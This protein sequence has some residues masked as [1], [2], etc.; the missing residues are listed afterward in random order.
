MNLDSKVLSW[1]KQFMVLTRMENEEGLKWSYRQTQWFSSWREGCDWRWVH[2]PFG[3]RVYVCTCVCVYVWEGSQVFKH[4]PFLS[5]FDNNKWPCVN[6]REFNNFCPAHIPHIKFYCFIVNNARGRQISYSS[7]SASV[8]QITDI[9][10]SINL[11]I[12]GF[13]LFWPTLLS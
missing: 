11:I 10:H 2:L 1:G 4:T 6:G 9:I 13:T 7:C 5:V 3:M 12:T 8:V